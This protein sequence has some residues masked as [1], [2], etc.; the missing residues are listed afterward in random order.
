MSVFAKQTKKGERWYY[1]FIV[2]GKYHRGGGFDSKEDA[3]NAELACRDISMPDLPEHVIRNRERCKQHYREHPDRDSERHL[4]RR[5]SISNE[6]YETLLAE[7]HGLCAICGKPPNRQRLSVDHSHRRNGRIRGLLC[8]KCNTGLGNFQDK[9]DL[10]LR[11]AL[12][13]GKPIQVQ[14]IIEIPSNQEQGETV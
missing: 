8:H 13:L 3:Q 4:Q 14:K 2:K 10:L 1:Q 5:Y 12:Y 11:A 9:L 6:Q 7:Q